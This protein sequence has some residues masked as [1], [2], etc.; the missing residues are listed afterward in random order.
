MP[1]VAFFFFLFYIL[2]M[3]KLQRCAVDGVL[4]QT[5]PP[6]YSRVSPVF[7]FQQVGQSKM[8]R[9]RCSVGPY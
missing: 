1:R 3:F 5:R 7:L 6:H 2:I 8:M 9:R 4:H